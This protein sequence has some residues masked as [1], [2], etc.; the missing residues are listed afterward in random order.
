MMEEG[1]FYFEP[2]TAD[3]SRQLK[4]D[5][6]Y[7]QGK[8]EYQLVQLFHNKIFGK[9]LFLDGKIQSAQIDEF[10]FHEALVH[11]ALI[12]HAAPRKVLIIG[13]GEGATLREALRHSCVEKTVMVD[14]DKKL[15]E[16]CQEHMPEW[17]D[18]AFSDSRTQ[19][20]F[21]DAR[22]YIEKTEQK[23]DVIVSDL[24]EP[25]NEG[26]SI[27]LFTREFFKKIYHSLEKDGIFVLQAGG[28]DPFYN[29]FFSS[30]AKTLE[31]IF[32]LVRPYWTFVFSF[33][34]PWGFI[35]A[36]KKTDP[37]EQDEKEISKRIRSRGIKNLKFYHP[38]FHQS[39]FS[40]P[41]YLMKALKK[42]RILT[43]KKPFIW[44][45]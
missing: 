34:N 31:E 38:G 17:S 18:G 10:I 42:G 9:V 16:L 22:R 43:D 25:V 14:I 40:L 41:V 7:Y 27:Y 1:L 12:I 26:S 4:V 45:A 30:C 39:L 23:F 20:I 36:S 33:N 28:T 2:F 44:E 29:Q 37:L 3:F 15:V 6:I 8:T 32:P 19:L 35:L 24:T 13:G 21:G 5:K 11:P